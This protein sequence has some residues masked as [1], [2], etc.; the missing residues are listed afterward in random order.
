M[1]FGLIRRQALRLFLVF[2]GLTGLLAIGSVLFWDFDE[3]QVKVLGTC[4]S[5]CSASICAMG[6]AAYIE[7]HGTRGWG[8]TGIVTALLGAAFFIGGIWLESDGDLYWKSTLTLI[9]VAVAVFHALLICL[10]TLEPGHRGVQHAGV[11]A[12]GVL[13][14]MLLILVWGEVPDGVYFQVLAAVSIVVGLITVSVP[15]LMRIRTEAG[16]PVRTLVLAH[17]EGDRYQTADGSLYQ[18]TALSTA[19]ATEASDGLDGVDS[20]DAPG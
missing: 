1:D 12:I 13:A 6:C 2:L 18:V 8:I 11:G 19:P 16:G 4:F 20:V 5:L 3:F 9:V 10:P 17:V 14:L 15:I 7:R